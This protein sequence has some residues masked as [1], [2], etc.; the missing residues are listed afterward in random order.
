[1]DQRKCFVSC[2]FFSLDQIPKIKKYHI[3]AKE[4]PEVIEGRG[5]LITVDVLDSEEASENSSVYHDGADS[6]EED[7]SCLLDAGVTEEMADIQKA[8]KYSSI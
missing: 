1:M 2:S 5:R 8:V 4:H 6:Y 3:V 7:G